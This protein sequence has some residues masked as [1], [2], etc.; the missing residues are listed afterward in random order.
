[1]YKKQIQGCFVPKKKDKINN[2]DSRIRNFVTDRI[3]LTRYL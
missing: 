3:S 2:D 1:M